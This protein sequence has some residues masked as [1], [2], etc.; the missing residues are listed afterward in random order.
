MEIVKFKDGKFGIRKQF[1]WFARY[2]DL[3]RDAESWEERNAQYFT[4][5]RGEYKEV[6]YRYEKLLE[7]RDIYSDKGTPIKKFLGEDK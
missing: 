4:D 3:K 5:C 7:A 1:L 2:L 6:K